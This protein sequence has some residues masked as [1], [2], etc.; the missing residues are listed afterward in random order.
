MVME[1]FAGYITSTYNL[2]F[3]FVQHL[4]LI[5]ILHGIGAQIDI[6]IK[7]LQSRLSWHLAQQ[8]K[9][10]VVIKQETG[11]NTKQDLF[12]QLIAGLVLLLALYIYDFKS[13]L[14]FY[15]SDNTRECYMERNKKYNWIPTKLSEKSF[16]SFILPH[17][18]KGKRGPKKS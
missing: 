15:K 2:L 8:G 12:K 5:D 18:L 13:I 10:Q 1:K 14:Q 3:S 16:T 6:L 11:N 17:L 4:F 9:V 7:I